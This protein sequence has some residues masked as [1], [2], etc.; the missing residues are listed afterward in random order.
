VVSYDINNQGMTLPIMLDFTNC[1]PAKPLTLK[2]TLTN[3]TLYIDQSLTNFEVDVSNYKAFAIV[4]QIT[5]G[6]FISTSLSL[7][8]TLLGIYASSY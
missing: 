5:N 2:Y 1:K 8:V 3:P 7:G 4:R 6:S